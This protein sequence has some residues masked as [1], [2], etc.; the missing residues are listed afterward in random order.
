MSKSEIFTTR[1]WV[2]KTKAEVF[3]FFSDLNNLVLLTPPLM[4]MNIDESF[5]A[6]KVKKDTSFQIKIG[7]RPLVLK[8]QS[9]ITDWNPSD[10]F[11]DMQ[12]TGPYSKWIHKH[13]FV[14]D[15]GGTW[16]VDEIEY[17]PKLFPTLGKYFYK[18]LLK[19]MFSYRDKQVKK[20]LYN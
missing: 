15:D 16:V 19:S 7:Y 12:T 9:E 1:E 13:S 5:L 14:E 10:H 4:N 11:A 20:L 2:N 17:I 8:W 6:D 3:D 18:L